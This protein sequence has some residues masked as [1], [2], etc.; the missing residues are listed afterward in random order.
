MADG[1]ICLEGNIQI[2]EMYESQPGQIRE[3]T[4]ALIRAVFGEGQG[5]VVSPS[6]SPYYRGA[7]ERCLEQYKA[8]VEAVLAWSG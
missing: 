1:R 6:A 5:L 2:E 8:M 4:E 3:E 7:G